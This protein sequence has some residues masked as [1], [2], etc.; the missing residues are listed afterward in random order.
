MGPP[1][2]IYGFPYAWERGRTSGTEGGISP[3]AASYFNFQS[4]SDQAHICPGT[5]L[6]FSFP[7]FVENVRSDFEIDKV[8]L[9]DYR[10]PN[11][12]GSLMRSADGT[13]LGLPLPSR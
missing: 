6:D 8:N 3:V 11:F 5:P 13:R 1:A 4:F 2:A 10:Q 9:D 7:Q 12:E